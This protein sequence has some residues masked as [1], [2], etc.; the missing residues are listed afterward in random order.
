MV[1]TPLIV[2]VT[3]MPYINEGF[4]APVI[5]APQKYPGGWYNV[6]EVNHFPIEQVEF[7]G[8]Q[9]MLHGWFI[10]VP[11]SKY[12]ALLNHGKGGNISWVQPEISL[13]TAHGM[14]VFAYDYGGYGRSEGKPSINNILQDA[15]DAYKYLVEQ[16][17][18]DP[19]HLILFGESLGTSVAANLSSKYP[20]AG[21]ILQCPLASL[22]RRGCEFIP[23]VAIYPEFMWPANG[24]NMETIFK[25]K[26][27]PLLM[28]AGTVD[29]MIP[30][31]THGDSIFKVAVEPK[32]Y[33]RVEGAG[34]TMDVKLLGSKKYHK[35]VADFMLTLN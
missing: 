16:R 20:C 24:L 31:Q 12:T 27:A 21:I 3:F 18:V 8:K 30:I 9:G 25:K 34:H 35:A 23:A 22:Q 11:N 1:L 2:Y 26:H 6:S 4:Y 5:F 14:S 10:A 7:K 32:Y 15:S 13:L 19:A 28:V 33:T 29:D 17:H